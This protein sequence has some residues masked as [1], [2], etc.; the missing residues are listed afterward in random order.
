MLVQ[1]AAGCLDWE[2]TDAICFGENSWQEDD[3]NVKHYVLWTATD[4]ELLFIYCWHGRDTPP[5]CRVTLWLW[6]SGAF[7]SLLQSW[8]NYSRV[9]DSD[10]KSYTT[11]GRQHW[12]HR[13][14]CS[15]EEREQS[16]RK[17]H[18]LVPSQFGLSV[19]SI[20]EGNGNLLFGRRGK[21]YFFSFRSKS[22][23]TASQCWPKLQ[24]VRLKG[25]VSAP[26]V[27]T[28]VLTDCNYCN[29]PVW[30]I[31]MWNMVLSMLFPHMMSSD[32]V[33]DSSGPEWRVVILGYIWSKVVLIQKK[34]V[35]WN[36][37]LWVC[38]FHKSDPGLCGADKLIYFI[39]L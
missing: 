8:L 29:S 27:V 22:L 15:G 23:D 3:G 16:L 37:V 32:Q 4:R 24:T 10:F 18:D 7:C 20:H 11:V 14:S 28:I 25:K 30:V 17:R 39:F 31:C 12:M 33:W 34:P 38:V 5:S 19:N 36:L 2:W 6:A 35:K 1:R 13:W 21:D 9:C 26:L